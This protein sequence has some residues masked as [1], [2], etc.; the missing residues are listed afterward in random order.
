[1]STEHAANWSW[2]NRRR[3]H[4]YLPTFKLTSI[5]P[6]TSI[7]RSTSNGLFTTHCI[8]YFIVY[9]HLLIFL[10]IFAAALLCYHARL[11]RSM[12]IGVNFTSC[13]DANFSFIILLFNSVVFNLPICRLMRASLARRLLF[14][15]MARMSQ[16]NTYG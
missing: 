3:W 10:Y 16:F 2:L 1:M 9:V 15:L 12:P 6:Q 8:F 11:L 4:K 13:V 14:P 5:R 7:D